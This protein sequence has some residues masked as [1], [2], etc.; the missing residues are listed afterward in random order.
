MAARIRR[1]CCLL[2]VCS[3]PVSAGFAADDPPRIEQTMAVTPRQSDVEYETPKQADFAKCR[4]EVERSGKVNGWVVIGPSGQILRKFLD[5]DG[6]KQ[7]DQ[8]RFYNH[9][10]EVYRDIDSNRN[11]KIDQFRW[12]NRAGTKWGIDKDEDGRVDQWKVLSAAEASKEAIRAMIARDNAALQAV[13]VTA[14]DLKSLGMTAEL[15]TRVLESA[16]DPGKKAKVIM[17]KTKVLTAQTKWSRFDAQMPSTIPVEEEKAST[18]LLIY[19]SANAI[20]ETPRKDPKQVFDAVQIGEMLRVGDVWKLT[21]VPMPIEGDVV[22][23]SPILMEPLQVA[24]SSQTA[25]PNPKMASVL[26]ELQDTEQRVQ[27]PKQSPEQMKTLMTKRSTLLK[28]AIDLAESEDEKMILMKQNVD[29]LAV[30]AQLGNYPEGVKDLRSIEA[31]LGRK[32]PKSPL[33]AYTAFRLIQA[34]NAVNTQEAGDNKEKAAECLKQWQES[35]ESFV[36]KYPGSD[37]ADD[38]MHNLGNHEE[39]QGHTKEALEWYQRIVSEKPKSNLAPRAQG[40]IRRM[41]LNGQ[42]LTIE[43]PLLDGGNLDARSLKGKVV[44]VVF[45]NSQ[46]ER[47]AE[48]CPALRALYHDNKM[49]G[50]EIVGVALENDKASAQAYVKSNNIQEWKQIF[51]APTTNQYGA[52]NSPL[53]VSFGIVL[54]PTM[55]LVNKE[56]VVVN[57]SATIADVKADLPELLKGTASK[58]SGARA[59]PPP[60]SSSKNN[61]SSPK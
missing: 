53:A 45:W 2:A 41:K 24:S 54:Y 34:E 33:I 6:D 61:S 55:F 15:A 50:F 30:A 48:D 47:C 21:Q 17:D 1:L 37:D 8:F 22:T 16:S 60:S 28:E 46:F 56:G 18:D 14:E 44:L 35:L 59:N 36:A 49:K 29:G 9:G 39:Y 23:S 26:L 40:A 3:M 13:M 11:K 27:Q 31:E 58:T 12:L 19:E 52:Q 10:V 38:A 43:G 51:Q 20:V 57:R 7:L 32:S 4:T 5:T 25:A 42:P